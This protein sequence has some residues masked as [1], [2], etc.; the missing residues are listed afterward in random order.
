MKI[1]L[2]QL[3]AYN[4][5]AN[6]LIIERIK[7]LPD[8]LKNQKVAS[9]FPSINATIWHVWNAESVWWQ[10]MKLQETIIQL[11]ESLATNFN[12]LG[13]GWMAQSKQFQEWIMNAQE[14][15]FDHEF[16]YYNFKKEK[17]K[18]KIYE[19]LIHVFNHGTYHRGQLVTIMRQLE[20]GNIPQTDFIVWSRRK[21]IV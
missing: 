18:Q 15:M 16:I 5:W 8:E 9:S 2:T 13:E 20:L 19:M 21:G 6:N 10:R 7:E 3:A 4:L 1:L 12:A 17:F 11:D 14:H